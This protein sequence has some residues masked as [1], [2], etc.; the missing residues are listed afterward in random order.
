[1]VA[2]RRRRL[3][4]ADQEVGPDAIGDEGLGAVDDVAT[5]DFARRRPDRGYVRAGAGLGDPEGSD[6]LALDPGDQPA[7]LLLLGAELPDRRR[8]DL[9]MR[10]QTRGY[11]AAAPR[12]RQL[13]DPDRIVDVVASLAAV[14]GLVF[15]A[16]EAELAAA[17]VELAGELA[18]LL[19]SLDVRRDL[20][21]DE[22][23]DGFPQLLVLLAEGRQRSS[24]A[25]VLYDGDGALQSASVV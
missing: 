18:R 17:V 10:S 9:G 24:L 14:L 2:T 23:A 20:L 19:P 6:Q 5:V 12:T 8:G 25:P 15:E 1:V 16:E 4:G 21:T 3:A 7:L 11:A 13:L 22:A